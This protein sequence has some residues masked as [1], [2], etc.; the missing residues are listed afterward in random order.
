MMGLTASQIRQDLSLVGEFGLQGYGYNV[1]DLYSGIGDVLGVNRNY[2]AVICGL[3]GIGAAL[4]IHP[5]FGV[6]GVILR[7][8]FDDKLEG[9]EI[10]NLT[11]MPMRDFEKWCSENKT[12]IA[13][14]CV[15][16]EFA[17]ETAGAAVKAGIC[18]IWNFTGEDIR[19][20]RAKNGVNIVNV[21]LHDSLMSLCCSLC[22]DDET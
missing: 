20:D 19:A 13:V 6:R 16:R 22:I 18:G 5:V 9:S 8:L 10:A 21:N 17:V 12:D 1:K 3:S 4:A 11:V 15:P 14:L 2:S 7:A